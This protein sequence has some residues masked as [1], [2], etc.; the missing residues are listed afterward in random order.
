MLTINLVEL[1]RRWRA[2]R[3][4]A[5]VHDGAARTAVVYLRCSRKRVK[6]L[7]D[8]HHADADLRAPP[9]RD[10][11]L[12]SHHFDGCDS[13]ARRDLSQALQVCATQTRTSWRV[14]RIRST[15]ATGICS[16]IRMKRCSRINQYSININQ[17]E[18]EGID[19]Y[20]AESIFDAEPGPGSGA[21]SHSIS[22]AVSISS[23]TT[24]AA[25]IW[26]EAQRI[27]TIRHTWGSSE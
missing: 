3:S 24:T 10:V 12:L 27:L 21:A 4:G 13:G 25:R 14:L 9:E 5:G 11:G 26:P 2:D 7:H 15:R 8:R 6:K 19:A 16:A 17:L 18:A 20:S 23:V 22:G 1:Y